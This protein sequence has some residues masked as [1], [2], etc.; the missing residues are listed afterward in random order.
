[1]NLLD[2]SG[3]QKKR[4]ALARALIQ[5]A[6]L[7]ILDEPT[8]HLDNATIV[9]LEHYLANY[10]GAILLVTHDRYFLNR[11]TNR[12][13]ELAHG[14][15]YEYEGNYEYYMEQ[16]LIR[17]EEERQ[18]EQK[19]A[20]RLRNEMAG[21]KGGA[22]ASSTKQQAR[23]EKIA[24]MHEETFHT[25]K[26]SVQIQVGSTRLG[27]EV[28]ELEGLAK[29][30]GDKTIWQDVDLLL[31]PHDRLGLIG[32]NGAGKSTLLE[33]IAGRLPYDAGQ[34]TI[35]ETV[36]IGY[37]KQGEEELDP[38]M[39]LIE[40]IKETADIIETVDG[41]VITAEQMLERFLFPR[42]KQWAYIKSLSGGERRRLYL[43]KIL[44]E[45]PN[46]LLLDEPTNDLDIETL[47]ILEEYIDHFPGV[48]LTV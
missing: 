44:M 13:Y 41:V 5:P 38:N 14:N 4:V 35:G 17:E 39:R 36:K 7:L 22:R 40:Y 28:L 1:A 45:E 18:A 27:K 42:P 34:M 46:V 20:N 8:N 26:E 16:R 10:N 6:D 21:V 33:V 30:F 31:K 37:Y 15:L 9:W 48:V 24:D 43:L 12:I 23:V 11:V 32:P 25:K 29:S 3:G 47:S 19:H 2:L